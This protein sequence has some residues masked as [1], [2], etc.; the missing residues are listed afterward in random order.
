[1]SMYDVFLSEDEDREQLVSGLTLAVITNTQDPENLGRV[2]LKYLLRDEAENESN[3]AR[4]MVPFAGSSMGVYWIPSVDDEVVVA[5]LG[6]RFDKP[7]V[8]GAVWSKTN[9]PPV[10]NEE[11][12]NYTKMIKTKAGHQISFVDESDKET[13][14]IESAKGQKIFIDDKNKLIEIKGEDGKNKVKIDSKEGNVELEAGTKISIKVGQS[15]IEISADKI[16]LKATS[17]ELKS[18]A[19]LKAEAGTTLDLKGSA[20]ATLEGGGSLTLKG[21]MTKIN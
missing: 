1:M 20:A 7:I 2:K 8:M 21:A 17:I 9:K 12:K 14:T 4:V 6:G 13:L 10:Q 5:F 3:W 16:A 18:S 15:A 19:G 11:G